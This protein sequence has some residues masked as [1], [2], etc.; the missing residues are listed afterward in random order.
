MKDDRKIYKKIEQAEYRANIL[1]AELNAVRQSKAYKLARSL[2]IIKNRVKS[3]PIGLT[4]KVLSI[5]VNDPKK[6]KNLLRSANRI[7]F[8]EQNVGDQTGK[9]QEWIIL[10]EPDEAELESQ[11][12]ESDNLKKKPLISIVTPVFNPPVD[13]L[14][15]LIESVLEQT[16]PNFELC[17]GDFGDDKDVADLLKKY[18]KLDKRIKYYVF[19]DNEGI[20]ENSN[21]I[22]AKVK[23]EYIALLDHDDT[24]S[25]DALF[26]NAKKINEKSYD[27]LYSDKDKID[28]N[29]NRFEPLFKPQLSPEMLLNINYLT[30]LNLMKTSIVREIGGWDSGTDGA[31]DWDIFLRVIASSAEVCHI[32]KILYHWRV[33]ES[34]TAMSI[35]AKPYAL[36]GQRKA[37]DK[38]LQLNK[39]PAKSY[40]KKTE[41][42]L[43]WNKNVIDR[44]PAVYIYFSN[45]SNTLRTIRY[46]RKQTLS[47]SFYVLI[48]SIYDLSPPNRAKL[49]DSGAKIYDLESGS[50]FQTIQSSFNKDNSKTSMFISDII[51][52]P[53]QEWYEDLTGWLTIKGVAAAG[54]RVVNRHDLIVDGG[55]LVTESGDYYPIFQG[56]PRFYQSYLGNAEWVRDLSIISS[57]FF[58]TKTSLLKKFNFSKNKQRNPMFDDFFLWASKKDR[59]VMTPHVSG[60]IYEEDIAFNPPHKLDLSNLETD[61]YID[62][63]GNINMSPK[64]PLKLFE[65][66]QSSSRERDETLALDKY[67]HDA[68][69]LADTFDISNDQIEANTKLLSRKNNKA[70]D[71]VAWFLPSF[72]AVYA[73]LM[74]IFSFAVY[75]SEQR[76]LKTTFYI[77]K[78][79]NDVSSE[80]KHA[81]SAFPALKNADFVALEPS[82]I[83]HI[84]HHDIGIATQWATTYPLA[85]TMSI[86]KKCYFIQ[87]NEVNF[88]PKGSISSLVELSYKFGFTAIANTSGLLDMYKKKYGGNG[89]VVKSVVD[90]TAY[91]PRKDLHYSPKAPYKVF[92]YA[93]PNM[94]RNAFELGVAGLKLLKNQLGKNVEIITAGADWDADSYGVTGMFTNLGKIDYAAVPKLYRSVDAG[95]MFMFSGHPGVTASELMASGCPVVVNEYDD[96]TWHDLYIDGKTCL[97]TKST[98]SE[99]SRNLRRCLEDHS[100]R[101]RLIEGGLKKTKEFYT[102]Y[103]SSQEVAYKKIVG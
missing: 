66:E 71:S 26:E 95:L 24:I 36:A 20:A 84:K 57:N 83:S 80:K 64:D 9:Y 70:P 3:D 21:K 48:S 89:I 7:S 8:L 90:L 92:F 16:Y 68:I 5:L 12:V 34:S 63:F 75:L 96:S 11:R 65:S 103:Q 67:Q 102:G 76:G 25:P 14:E 42:F 94:P 10:N 99:V 86:A 49:K 73:G 2:S 85:K 41:M 33:I 40:H 61:E 18:T 79:M 46:I 87:D 15:D 52:L 58:V 72:D 37:V 13:V 54:G 28:I 88:Y 27:F 35:E 62:R 97:V 19:K 43:E 29:G 74:N 45:V 50:L 31:Q 38:F 44:D 47:P 4:K 56:Y 69:I 53:K 100:L 30:H 101:K 6:L 98:A 59:I 23:G 39:I 81:M 93:R 77:L 78:D 51:R 60:S 91:T 17:L 32:P 55:A 82:R 1:E 22:L